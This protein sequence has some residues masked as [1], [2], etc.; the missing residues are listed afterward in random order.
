MNNLIIRVKYDGPCAFGLT[1]VWEMHDEEGHLIDRGWEF[2]RKRANRAARRRAKR[3]AN[4]LALQERYSDWQVEVESV[5]FWAATMRWRA[6][7]WVTIAPFVVATLV[8]ITSIVL[9]LGGK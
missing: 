3:E 5:S 6:R 2:T 7:P 4:E 1:W 8:L 9:G